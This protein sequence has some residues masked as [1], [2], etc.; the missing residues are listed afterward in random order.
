VFDK[1]RKYRVNI[2]LGYFNAKVGNEEICKPT[3]GNESLHEITR[4]FVI[5]T[6]RQV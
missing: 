2:L 5:F 1:F 6:L 3:V 4:S